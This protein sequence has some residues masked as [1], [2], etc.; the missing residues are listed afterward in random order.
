VRLFKQKAHSQEQIPYAIIL[1]PWVVTRRL[2]PKPSGTATILTGKEV[3]ALHPVWLSSVV[4]AR[5]RPFPVRIPDARCW[6]DWRRARGR[7]W[8][9]RWC[10]GCGRCR[11]RSP[12]KVCAHHV[13]SIIAILHVVVKEFSRPTGVIIQRGAVFAMAIPGAVGRAD[14]HA[15]TRRRASVG[16]LRKRNR[17]E[18]GSVGK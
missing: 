10:H 15:G 1:R 5:I 11:Q 17:G 2:P 6:Q 9:P 8:C 13:C 12:T 14:Q 7:W 16:L 3:I 4:S 18:E